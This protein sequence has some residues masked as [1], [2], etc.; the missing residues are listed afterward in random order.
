VPRA[1]PR[2]TRRT[3]RL[4]RSTWVATGAGLTAGLLL[5]ALVL[6]TGLDLLSP[7]GTWPRL[8]ALLLVVVP[9]AWAAF[10]GV[11]RPLFRRLREVQ[12]ARR[13]E[14]T[15]PGIH[16]RLVSCIDLEKRGPGAASATFHRRLLTEALERVRGFRP[17]AVL[18]LL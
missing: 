18:D 5:A 14:A 12:V 6:T 17:R 3:R 2:L 16:N 11:V 8:A 1:R 7:L 15:L 4:L 13:I 9:A 10:A